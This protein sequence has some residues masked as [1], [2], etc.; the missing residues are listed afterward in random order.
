METPN[1]KKSRNSA[2]CCFSCSLLT[3]HTPLKSWQTAGSPQNVRCFPSWV[4]MG[5][6]LPF[7]G[8]PFFQFP[9]AM[10]TELELGLHWVEDF[11]FF[12]PLIWQVIFKHQWSV[13]PPRN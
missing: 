5:S 6:S 12:C 2:R 4:H 11:R 7:W 1:P 13:T 9:P 10:F 3:F 8:G